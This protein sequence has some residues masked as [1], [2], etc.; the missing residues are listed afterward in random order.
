MPVQYS[1]DTNGCFARW[2]QEGAKYYYKCGSALSRSRAKAKAVDQGKAIG[3]FGYKEQILKVFS[4]IFANEKISFDYDETL[5]KSAI[6]DKALEYIRTGADVYIISASHDKEKMLSLAEKLGIIES[7]VYATGS[8]KA[9]VEKII[10]LKIS[11]HY[12]N[13]PDVISE[14]GSI[15]ELV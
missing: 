2:G 11:K 9:K 4:F 8:N 7:R 12:D 10:E 14:L 1:K 5:T 15:G 13:N 6:Q 3:E